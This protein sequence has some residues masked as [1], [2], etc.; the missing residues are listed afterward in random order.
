MIEK[1]CRIAIGID[2]NAI[3]EDDDSLR[4][5]RL[6]H[7]LHVGTGFTVATSR[8]Q[9]LGMAFANGRRSVTNV[10]DGGAVTGGAPADLLLLDWAALDNDHL[11]E[12]ADVLGI[13][14]ARA[15]ARHIHE[16]IVGGRTVVR[17]GKVLGV[18]LPAARAQIIAQMRAGVRANAEFGATLPALEK[19]LAAHF[20]PECC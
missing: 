6:A 7:L 10:D 13:L 11:L 20:E 14:F 16:L 18:D 5:F 1:G 3:D 15:T 8:E 4:E 17:D 19:A 9:V 2:G 12:E